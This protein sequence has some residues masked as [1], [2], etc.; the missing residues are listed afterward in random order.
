MQVLLPRK[1]QP[2]VQLNRLFRDVHKRGV[3]GGFRNR[4][5]F[6]ERVGPLV[7]DR[8]RV[9]HGRARLLD[10][11]QHVR[12]LVLDGL[13]CADRAAEL[14]AA[15]GVVDSHVEQL[16]GAPHHLGGQG[17]RR[18]VQDRLQILQR[19]LADPLEVRGSANDLE[20]GP[21]HVHRVQ[22][23]TLGHV[24]HG[25]FD[26][27]V[28]RAVQEEP[29]ARL[30]RV[31]HVTFRRG[32]PAADPP[33]R[34]CPSRTRFVD[35]YGRPE[36]AIRN[37]GKMPAASGSA[38]Q[39]FQRQRGQD[40]R[41]VERARNQ[42]AAGLFHEYREI[43]QAEA[44][45]LVLFADEQAGPPEVGDLPPKGFGRGR[46]V[47]GVQHAAQFGDRPFL[48]QEFA[49]RIAQEHLFFGQAEIHGCAPYLRGRPRMRSAMT[50]RSTSEVPPSMVFARERR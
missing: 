13:E 6:R 25:K 2:A 49:R 35:A 36:A 31:R 26:R 30:R 11:D 33:I 43:E 45:A 37:A 12:R 1:A 41:R 22:V 21:G 9:I 14:L 24:R 39:R 18:L 4:R 10:P 19:T 23:P 38:A 5:G 27:V 3:G 32:V 16:R 28:A 40:A 15:L 50:V 7:G 17:D 47:A 46:G 42:P 34:R 29:Q 20:K 44:Q 48:I 8:S